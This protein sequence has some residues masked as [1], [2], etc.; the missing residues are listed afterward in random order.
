MRCAALACILT[1]ALAATASAQEYDLLLKGGH[2]VDPRNGVSGVRDVAVKDG[3]IARVA[4]DIPAAQALKTV[5][6]SGLHVTPGLVDIHVHIYAGEKDNQYSGGDRSLYPDGF[7]L[8]NCVTTVADAGS[9]GWRTFDDFRTRIVDRSRTRVT[10]FIN[11]VGAGM[12]PGALE[13]NVADMDVAAT[14]AMARRHRD[15]VVGVKSAHYNGT[16][17]MPYE[18]AGEV[19]R[20]FDAP[21]MV[22]FGGNV[23]AG[24][25]LM[26]LFTKYF[27]PGDIYTHMYG[28]RRGEQDPDTKG[29]SAA[30]V[31]GRRRGILF[32]VGHGG[33][34]FRYDA[35]V[36]MLKAGFGPDSISTDLHGGSMNTA[37]KGMINLMG[38]FMAMGVPFDDVIRQSTWN[39]ARQIRR[40]DLGHLS[41]GAPADIAVLKIEEGRFGFIDP[42]GGR[43]DASRRLSCELTV[44]DGKVLYDLNGLAR[45]P[46]ETLAPDARGGDPRWDGY[47]RR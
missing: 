12:A 35:A 42:P 20:Q 11:I 22:D 17:W 8:R 31:E 15:V 38:K 39:P 28:G 14:A 40:E 5:D 18:R 33:A 9:A 27:R 25:T 23:R 7:T 32:D 1:A 41:A 4:P 29:P 37:M 19:A 45:E 21:V 6:V 3:R 44:R 10:A 46:W 43:M 36:P 34:S 2:V 13:Q 30:M 16:D 24:R 47:S 26:E